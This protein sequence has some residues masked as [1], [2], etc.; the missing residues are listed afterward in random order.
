MCYEKYQYLQAC[1]GRAM[2]R[3]MGVLWACYG[4]AMRTCA[5]GVL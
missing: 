4:R 1:Y 5:M 2:R 3:A